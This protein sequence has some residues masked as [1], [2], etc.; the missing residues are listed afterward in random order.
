MIFKFIIDNLEN[1][2]K[3]LHKSYILFKYSNI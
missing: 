2:I 3:S 1:K